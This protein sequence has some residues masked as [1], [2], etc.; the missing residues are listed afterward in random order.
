MKPLI[1]RLLVFLS[2]S[3]IKLFFLV[4]WLLLILYTLIW[5][6]ISLQGALAG[7]I[8]PLAFFY[9][10]GSTFS[11]LSRQSQQLAGGAKLHLLALS[12]AFI[13]QILKTVISLI[14]PNQ[15]TLPII[16]GWL[17]LAH[18]RNLRGSWLVEI[19][20]FT[21]VSHTVLVIFVLPF[22]LGTLIGHGYYTTRYRKS[23]WADAAFLGLFSGL[24][25]AL[26]DLILR[27]YTLDFIQVPGIVTADLKD[28]LITIAIAAFFAEAYENPNI[29]LLRWH[30]VRQEIDAGRQLLADVL[31]YTR[32]EIAQLWAA[33]LNWWKAKLG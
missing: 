2:P 3:L 16:Q 10:V 23:V 5:D 22:L 13:D 26:C 33:F 6:G 21:F 7:S 27:G 11:A 31:S 4:E 19:F 24:L 1:A 9:L 25:S 32:Q 8:L 18:E 14:I 15:N 28:V 30:G 20:D 12:L 17:H 29:A